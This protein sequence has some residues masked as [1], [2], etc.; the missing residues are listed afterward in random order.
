MDYLW[1]TEK[2]SR[3]FSIVEIGTGRIGKR[4]GAD[5]ISIRTAMA[6]SYL[7]ATLFIHNPRELEPV[8]EVLSLPLVAYR[9][10]NARQGEQLLAA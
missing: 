5:P 4:D 7:P 3:Q 2:Q 9:S 8:H 1:Q 10:W 6:N